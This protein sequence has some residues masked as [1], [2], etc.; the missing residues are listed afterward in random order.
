[1]FKI[2]DRVV[3][4]HIDYVSKDLHGKSGIVVPHNIRK[5]KKTHTWIQLDE[6]LLSYD[7]KDIRTFPHYCYEPESKLHKVLK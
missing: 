5:L 6:P 2:G 1:M 4:K 7:D 3:I